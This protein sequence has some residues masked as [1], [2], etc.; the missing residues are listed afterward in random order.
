MQRGLSGH[1]RPTIR[2]FP[3]LVRFRAAGGY[4]AKIHVDFHRVRRLSVA[5]LFYN[6]WK[7]SN[8]ITID[9]L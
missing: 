1:V 3:F 4:A 8:K 5:F 6:L 9:Y 2:F 7:V